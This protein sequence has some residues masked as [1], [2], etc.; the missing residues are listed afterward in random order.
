M[1]RD[2]GVDGVCLE[3]DPGGAGDPPVPVGATDGAEQASIIA[4]GAVTSPGT[5]WIICDG[6]SG[7]L[8]IYPGFNRAGNGGDGAGKHADWIIVVARTLIVLGGEVLAGEVILENDLV[9]VGD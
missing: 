4:G 7:E 8:C 3:C 5:P 1:G 2:G 9:V 6:K